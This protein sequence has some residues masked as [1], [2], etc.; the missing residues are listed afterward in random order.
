MSIVAS[1][2]KDVRGKDVKRILHPLHYI[3]HLAGPRGIEPRSPVLE[4]GV[5]PLNYGPFDKL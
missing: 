5:L 1:T 4:T 2:L 3:L